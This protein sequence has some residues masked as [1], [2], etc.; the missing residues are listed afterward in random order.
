MK[1]AEAEEAMKRILA[2]AENRVAV[3]I[4]DEHGD[5]VLAHRMDGCRERFMTVSIHK[6]Y[7]SARMDR[8]TESFG[9]MIVKR[10]LQISYYGDPMFTALP[11]GIPIIGHDG[12]TLGGIGVTGLIIGRDAAIAALGLPC[13]TGCD[14]QAKGR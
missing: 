2:A 7:T 9:E 14:P 1:V 13:F 12:S 8:T 3:A 6:A 4:V 11:G 5:L 10:Q